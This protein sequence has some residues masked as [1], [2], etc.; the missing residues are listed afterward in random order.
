[1]LG[2]NKK[3]PSANTKGLEIDELPLLDTFRTFMGDVLIDNIKL[4]QL[5]FQ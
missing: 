1:M 4:N 2:A 3:S 5:V